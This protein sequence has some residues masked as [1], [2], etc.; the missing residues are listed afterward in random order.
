MPESSA[1]QT[2]FYGYTVAG[3][4]CFCLVLVFSVHYAFGVFFKPL[5]SEFG[6]TRAMTAGAFSLVWISQGLLAFVMGGVNDRFGPR[7]V[8]TVCA[9][10]VGAGWLL[11]SQLTELWQLYLYY[12]VIVGAGLGGTFVPLTSTTARWFVARRGLMTGIV[13]AGVGIGTFIGP[14]VAT[15]IISTYSWRAGYFILGTVVLVG[16][17]AAAQ[18]LVRDPGQRGQR[19]LGASEPSHAS[20]VAGLELREA[21]AS[22]AFWTACAAFFCYGFSL[23]AILLHLAPH[24]TDLGLSAG[25]AAALLS[26]VGAA[27]VAGKVLLGMVS[28]Y[29]GYKQVFVVSFLLMAVSL[30]MLVPARSAVLL[31][32][33]AAVFG[34]AYGGLATAHSPLVAWLFGLRR[35]GRIFGLSFNG[36][37]VGCAVGPLVAGYL[38][39]TQASYQLAFLL[40]A[41]SAALGFLLTLSLQPAAQGFSASPSV[42][43]RPA[44]LAAE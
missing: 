34:L 28:D 29:V 4:A 23:S 21:T 17:T 2:P 8:L 1:R 40:C 38:F 43:L 14:P 16:T 25:T 41:A 39:D 44:G 11:T 26:T 10:L 30:L 19:P 42:P 13:T 36:W 32:A 22:R 31:Y 9:M 20:D 5:S 7:V 24:A 37:T 18:L 6:W 12:G 33:F 35:H 27:S 15:W 3:A